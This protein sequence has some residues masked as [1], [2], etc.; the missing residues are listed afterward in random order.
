[1]TRKT[2]DWQAVETYLLDGHTKAEAAIKYD[3]AP[4]SFNKARNA[5][6]I[7]ISAEFLRKNCGP[8]NK[9]LED[10]LV[11]NS[12]ISS[13]HLKLR[14]I[15]AG[16]LEYKCKR[17]GIDQWLNNKLVLQLD[18][19]NGD[20]YD[21]RIENLRL[22]C[23]NCHSQTPTFNV[24]NKKMSLQRILEALKGGTIDA[25]EARLLIVE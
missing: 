20:H 24:G 10:Y 5:G 21:N 8:K 9:P 11:K 13:N 1:M 18:H 17:C 2:I 15:K 16:V 14:L 22:L 3:F 12:S 25:Q 4:Y 23:P 6:K 7:N 19:I